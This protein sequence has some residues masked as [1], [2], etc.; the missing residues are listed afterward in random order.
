MAL[1]Q[2][3]RER[4]TLGPL[5]NISFANSTQ[6]NRPK[7]LNAF[8]GSM[9]PETIAAL[10]ELN[11]HPETVMTVITGEGRFFAAGADVNSEYQTQSLGSLLLW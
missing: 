11:D 9:I 5:T 2:S 1:A 6:F 3:R 7:S 4:P 8:G 10:R